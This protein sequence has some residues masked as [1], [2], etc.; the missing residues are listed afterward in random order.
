MQVFE[1]NDNTK[2]PSQQT[3]LPLEREK[4]NLVSGINAKHNRK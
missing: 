3:I 2:S 4:Q 1:T